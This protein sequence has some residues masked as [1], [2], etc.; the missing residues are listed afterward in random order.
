MDAAKIILSNSDKNIKFLIIGEGPMENEIKDY[1]KNLDLTKD[2]IF[3][4]F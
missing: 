3:T 4:R 1:C 2:V